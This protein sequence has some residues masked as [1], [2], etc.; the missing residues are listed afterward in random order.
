MLQ[1]VTKWMALFFVGSAVAIVLMQTGCGML[2]PAEEEYPSDLSIQ[3]L[4]QRMKVASDP[5]GIFG[6]SNSYVQKQMLESK[7]TFGSPETLIVEVKFKRPDMFKTTTL[8]DNQPVMSVI[9]NGKEA[10]LVNYDAKTAVKI[11]GEKFNR[12]KLLF[13]LARP[14]NT[15]TEIFPDVKLTQ[16]RINDEEFYKLNCA[17]PKV[18]KEP[19][20]LYVGK[21][22][23]LIKKLET[24]EN[25]NGD[26]SKYTA[27]M[28]SYYLH[29]GVMIAKEVTANDNGLHQNYK[30]IYYKLNAT[31]DSAEFAPPAWE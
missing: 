14:D 5:D 3:Q 7:K 4:Q 23:F 27:V 13:A 18:Q 26:L 21:N 20:I 9:F 8:K 22:N 10:W 25:L 17:D 1:I 2:K 29:D 16:C 31:I 19:F 11:E 30:V 6:K 12:L 15:Y 28:D 24:V